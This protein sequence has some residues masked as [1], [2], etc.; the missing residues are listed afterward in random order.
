VDLLP[1][2]EVRDR[3]RIVGQV[4]GGVQTIPVRQIIGSL[5]RPSDFDRD[6]RPRHRFSRERLA[7]LRATFPAEGALPPI[8]A[9][10]AGGAY[11]VSDGHHRVALARERGSEYI[12]A[13]ITHLITM[14][15]YRLMSTCARWCTPNN[16][17]F[18]PRTAGLPRYAPTLGS[19]SHDRADIPNC[20]KV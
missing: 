8:E 15:K 4:Y 20:S 13:E 17:G 1:L 14:S 9:H 18:S 19:S 16:S 11:F 7:G 6:F 2:G 10:E 3:L 5:A 12:D